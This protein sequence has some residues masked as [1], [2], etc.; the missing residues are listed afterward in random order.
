MDLTRGLREGMEPTM[1][2]MPVSMIDHRT[3]L[4][5]LTARV[6]SCSSSDLVFDY[7][8]ERSCVAEYESMYLMRTMV[9]ALAL[10]H[11]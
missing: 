5:T 6:I 1:M 11:N 7:L 4:D 3:T 2:A 10:K 8:H 9:A